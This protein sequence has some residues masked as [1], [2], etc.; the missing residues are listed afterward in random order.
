MRRLA[1]LMTVAAALLAL[2]GCSSHAA[3]SSVKPAAAPW[4]QDDE[5]YLTV[6]ERNDPAVTVAPKTS[7]AYLLIKAGRHF[8]D[9]TLTS[10]QQFDAAGSDLFGTK[11]D[12]SGQGNVY[13]AM[14]EAAVGVFCPD[15][16]V[17]NGG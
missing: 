3:P 12:V 8:C 11:Y 13:E 9:T 16:L 15:Q 17:G 1:L 5:T 2:A 10:D 7:D 14:S 6:L 4:T